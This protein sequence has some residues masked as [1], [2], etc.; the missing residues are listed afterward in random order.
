MDKPRF[1]TIIIYFEIFFNSL[2]CSNYGLYK[3]IYSSSLGSY[4]FDANTAFKTRHKCL[5]I[6]NTSYFKCLS[7]CSSRNNCSSV[8]ITKYNS[9]YS[10]CLGVD[11]YIDINTDVTATYD[12]IINQK[13]LYSLNFGLTGI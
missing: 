3:I 8:V 10:L 7:K 13:I 1:F 6:E 9:S 11:V 2:V 12:Q 5:E 4:S